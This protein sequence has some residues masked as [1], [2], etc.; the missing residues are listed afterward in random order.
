MLG[1]DSG[2]FLCFCLR[3]SLSFRLWGGRSDQ[4]WIVRDSLG[5]ATHAANMQGVGPSQ[6]GALWASPPTPVKRLGDLGW[7][8]M[9]WAGRSGSQ[10]PLPPLHMAH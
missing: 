8:R 3:R 5:E 10:Q 1:G 7:T 4:V 9:V 6:G 2:R